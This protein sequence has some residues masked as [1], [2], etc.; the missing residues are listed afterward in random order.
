MW[1]RKLVLG[2]IVAVFSLL[3]L[4]LF[5]VPSVLSPQAASCKDNRP[6]IYLLYAS[7]GSVSQLLN[8]NQ[9]DSFIIWEPVV[10]NAELS[11]IG[12]RIAVPSDLPPPGNGGCC[13][14]CLCAQ[15]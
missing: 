1:G 10:A 4:S 7:S 5:L 14:L 3:L 6:V 13:K 9:I 12:K 15:K 8:T 2:F 11:G